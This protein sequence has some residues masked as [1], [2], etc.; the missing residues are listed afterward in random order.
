M[1][2]TDRSTHRGASESVDFPEPHLHAFDGH[3]FSDVIDDDNGVGVAVEGGHD[4]PE[5]VLSRSVPD[6]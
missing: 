4:V 5:A 2:G 3:K 6:L 1:H